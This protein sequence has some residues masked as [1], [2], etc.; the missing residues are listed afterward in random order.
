VW[1]LLWTAVGGLFALNA[2]VLAVVVVSATREARKREE[3]IRELDAP[4]RAGRRQIVGSRWRKASRAASRSRAGTLAGWGLVAALLLTGTAFAS[5]QAREIVGSVLGTVTG[6]LGVGPG[7]RQ[8]LAGGDRAAAG[9]GARQI[10]SAVGTG[11]RNSTTGPGTV[12]AVGSDPAAGRIPEAPPTVSA[13][14][15]SSTEIALLWTDVANETGYRVERRSNEDFDWIQVAI[16]DPGITTVTDA[17]LDSDTTY[18]YRVFAINELIDSPP[19][20]VTSA[21]TTIDPP[22][23]PTVTVSLASPHEIVLD[24]VDVANETGYRIERSSDGTTGW[25]TIATPGENVIRYSDTGLSADV[26]LY[27]RVVATNAGGDSQAS[28]V[29]WATTPTDAPPS[30]VTDEPS[31]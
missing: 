21:T 13:V 16:T 11:P 9:S 27:Y 20:D 2:I 19:S 29:A 10:P 17:G 6:G 18:D 3:E 30:E 15:Q 1:R 31:P 14:A 8:G 7:E 12:D 25:I 28:D 22:G 4:R 24:W 26:T 23:R 5:P